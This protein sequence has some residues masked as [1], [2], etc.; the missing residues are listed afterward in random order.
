MKKYCNGRWSTSHDFLFD[1]D[2]DFLVSLSMNLSNY[3]STVG[4]DLED[5][6]DYGFSLYRIKG[7]EINLPTELSLYEPEFTDRYHSPIVLVQ[8][9]R[10]TIYDIDMVPVTIS[11]FPEIL[12]S[13]ELL[14]RKSDLSKD[15]W[16]AILN[17][18]SRNSK[19][20]LEHW[21]NDGEDGFSSVEVRDILTNVQ[22]Q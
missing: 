1:S 12:N 7:N 6:A 10:N 18:I 8:G 22:N 5:I 2:Y 11:E 20:L 14:R 4:T 16:D 21:N 9:K 17:F 13:P 19:T 15:E 3:E